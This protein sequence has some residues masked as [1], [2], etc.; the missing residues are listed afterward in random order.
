MNPMVRL[1]H[2]GSAVVDLVYRIPRL[3]ERGGEAVARRFD[4]LPGGGF[5]VMAA[6]RRSGMRVAYAGPHGSGPN[7]DFLREAMA[8]ED[9]EILLPPT[10]GLDTGTCVVLVTDD[11]ER[12]FVSHAGAE[13]HAEEAALASL[14]LGPG[15]VVFTSGYSL[16]YPG[17]VDAVSRLV[18]TLPAETPFVLDPAPVVTE[19]PAGILGRMLARVTWLSL[20]RAEA[21]VIAG[22]GDDG[23]LAERL[24]RRHCPRA[25]GVILRRGEAGCILAQPGRGLTEVAAFP[26]EAIDTNGA[27][28]VHVGA[29]L[30]SLSGGD[31]PAAAVRFA[32]AAA[33]LSTTRTGGGDAPTRNEIL[34]FM[35]RYGRGTP[36]AER[37][38]GD[39]AANPG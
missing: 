8:R 2:V 36:N 3:P 18:E 10:P 12:T 30:A 29:F 15:D 25:S 13:G 27:G 9:I 38:I 23:E 16:S 24:L 4:R 37:T 33:A 19:V 5:N 26:V 28:D 22:E 21:R 35:N 14:P 31:D 34:D 39:F 11:A 20:N 17:S 6:A 32:N 7:G 1:V